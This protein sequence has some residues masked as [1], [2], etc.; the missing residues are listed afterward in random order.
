[1]TVLQIL[2]RSADFLARKGIEQARLNSELL[3]SHVLH[4][5]RLKLYLNFEREVSEIEMETLRELLRRRAAR[6]P[7]QHIIGSTSFCGLEI[8]VTAAALV[9]RP[10][11]E[12]LA[13]L[14]WK[15]LAQ[16]NQASTQ[17]LDFGTGTGCIAI[18]LAKHAP[19]AQ[20]I[21]L[22][23]SQGALELAAANVAA[24]QMQD[25][26]QLMLPDIFDQSSQEMQFDLIITNPPY[27]PTAEITSLAPEVKNHD[28]HL[29]LDGGVDGL[30]LY[31][32][33]AKN[34]QPK[35]LPEGKL[36][37]EFGDGQEVAVTEIF[38][39]EGWNVESIVCDY[40]K[41]PRILIAQK[42]KS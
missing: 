31:R 40:N 20:I 3:L 14:G 18:A 21:A 27:I 1:M 4:L 37:A 10:E 19:T 39:N 23:I 34:S 7:L 30:D 2:Q 28:P 22:D 6:E 42:Q 29:A 5:P 8:K 24:H 25:R 9:P 41:K 15:F 12:M 35:L 32:M 11:T 16:L 17:V 26:I 36:M 33:L 38:R 13:E